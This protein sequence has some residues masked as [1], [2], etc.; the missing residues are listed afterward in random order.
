MPI[1]ERIIVRNA[2]DLSG[3]LDSTILYFVDGVI[4]M[5]STSIEVPPT[6][7]QIQG[8]GFGVSKLISSNSSFTLFVT[9]GTYS[10]NLFMENL[11]IE[12]TGT[13]SQVFNLDNDG[14]FS[15]VEMN[16]V[17]FNNCTSLGTLDAYRQG[18]ETNTG[19]FGGTPNL[20]LAGTWVGGYRITTSIVRSLSSGMTGALFQEGTSFTMASRFLT[21]INCDLPTSAAFAD[22][23]TNN[24]TSPSLFQIKGAIFTR[25]GTSDATDTNILPN[26]DRGDLSASWKDN[27]GIRNTYEGG[28]ND[29]SS[30]NLTVISAGSTFYTL[31][32]VWTT[33]ALQHFDSPA[34]GQ[35]RHLGNN[36]REY[37]FTADL[38]IE[39]TRNDELEVRLRKYDASS[40]TTSTVDS[41]RRQ[42]NNLA[43]GRDVAF[44]TLL[45]NVALD[46]NDYVFL[47]IA[48]NSGNNN[49]TLELDSFYILDSR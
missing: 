37:R 28:R 42:V 25:N 44:F 32:A 3:T 14:N 19:R 49:A 43:G 12:I 45:S 27:Q 35:L 33:S 6:G 4:D 17:N 16:T 11:E 36:P 31:N 26:I 7:L 13:G 2:S 38:S 9:D 5:G 30:E 41:Q 29:V 18:L 10:G 47:E 39:S 20:T 46:Q 48:N 15:A 24:F 22:F 23:D 8:L 34:A 40:T 21:D 1:K